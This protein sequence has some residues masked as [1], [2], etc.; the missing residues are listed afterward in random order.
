MRRL[1]HLLL[2]PPS[3]FARLILGEKRLA[4]DPV[5]ADDSNMHLP[6]FVDLDGTRCEGLWAIV[7]HLEGTYPE[8]PLVPEEAAA[9]A[10]CLRLL[11]WSMGPFQE[12]VTRRIVFEKAAQRFTGAP[13]QRAPDMNI[14]RAGRDALKDTLTM[15]GTAAEEHGYLACRD[16]TLGDLAMAAHISALDYY[17]E[18]PWKEF[19]QASEWYVRMKSRPSFRSLLGDRVPGQPPVAHYAELDA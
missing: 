15:L 4:Y 13:A 18:V 8:Q 14:V 12:A 16:C 6:V 1:T 3:R 19:P 17:G 10:E 11:D 2:S 9:R 7:D 5:P